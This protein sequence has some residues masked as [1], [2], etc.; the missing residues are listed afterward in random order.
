MTPSERA[1]QIDKEEFA[2]ES[3]ALLKRALAYSARKR[4][5]EHSRMIGVAVLD[6]PLKNKPTRRRPPRGKLFEVGGVER[7]LNQWA[8]IVGIS[9]GSMFSRVASYGIERAVAM[10]AKADRWTRAANSNTPGVSS[11]FAPS[12]GTGAGSTAQEIPNLNFSDKAENA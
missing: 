5:D 9:Y 7:T 1:R 6:T 8:N 3:A 10:G 12:K 2:A 4:A 11:D